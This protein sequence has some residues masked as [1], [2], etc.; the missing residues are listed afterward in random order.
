MAQAEDCPFGVGFVMPSADAIDVVSMV[1]EQFTPKD[2][3]V[4]ELCWV[5]SDF[6][7]CERWGLYVFNCKYKSSRYSCVPYLIAETAEKAEELR[8]WALV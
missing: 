2:I 1:I 6:F 3:P 4:G 7:N 8:D 5:K